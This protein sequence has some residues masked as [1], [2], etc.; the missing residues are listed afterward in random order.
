MHLH[1]CHDQSPSGIFHQHAIEQLA[2]YG[3]SAL[4]PDNIASLSGVETVYQSSQDL[5]LGVILFG[6]EELNSRLNRNMSEAQGFAEKLFQACSTYFNMALECPPLLEL[7]FGINE[8]DSK[9]KLKVVRRRLFKVI[10]Q[11][12]ALGS[13]QDILK[14]TNTKSAAVA[15]WSYIHGYTFLAIREGQA[16]ERKEESLH[17]LY[18]QL[19][20]LLCKSFSK[21]DI[22]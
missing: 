8:L 14:T 2:I 10:E 20:K 21:L 4:C 5:K 13:R 7:M 15:T 6:F 22:S 16:L 12:M 11:V 17:E 19:I 3:D 9:D 18:H 1:E